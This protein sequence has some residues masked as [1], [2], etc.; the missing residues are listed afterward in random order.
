[1]YCFQFSQLWNPLCYLWDSCGICLYQVMLI[2]RSFQL[3][4]LS[5]RIGVNDLLLC[6]LMKNPCHRTVQALTLVNM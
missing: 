6:S 1:M 5:E 4:S 2:S 3:V